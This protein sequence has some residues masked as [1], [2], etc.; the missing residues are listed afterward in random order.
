MRIAACHKQTDWVQ[1]ELALRWRVRSKDGRKG[2]RT[3]G[4][5]T[6]RKLSGR[7]VSHILFYYV[8]ALF[9]IA[10]IA[11]QIYARYKRGY[12][13]DER[14]AGLIFA[15]QALGRTTVRAIA[16]GRIDCLGD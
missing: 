13:K 2:T 1:K 10:V 14:F 7:D 8:Y 11:Q 6:S 15:V 5:T 12:T 16:K 4:L 3:P 9:K